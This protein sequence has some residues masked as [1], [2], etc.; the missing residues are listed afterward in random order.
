MSARRAATVLVLLAIASCEQP[1]ANPRILEKY[2]DTFFRE[3]R[4]ALDQPMDSLARRESFERARQSAQAIDRASGLATGLPSSLDL[5]LAAET[6]PR[7]A[8]V[9]ALENIVDGEAD[10]HT[11]RLAQGQLERDPKWLSESLTSDSLYSDF[12]AFLNG[13]A[14]TVSAALTGNPIGTLQPLILGI[15]GVV[16]G[17]PLDPRDRKRIVLERRLRLE[18]ESTSGAAYAELKERVEQLADQT[19][20]EELWL[21]ARSVESGDFAAALAHLAVAETLDLRAEECVALKSRIE[22]AVRARNRLL[23]TSLVVEPTGSESGTEIDAMLMRPYAGAPSS[24]GNTLFQAVGVH[25]GKDWFL[26]ADFEI[27]SARLL[28]W[29]AAW[30]FVFTG[31]RD[32]A[33]AL[34]HYVAAR[35]AETRSWLDVL[36]PIL[37]VPSTLVRGGYAIF[38]DPIDDRALIDAEVRFV[39]RNPSDERR[40]DILVELAERYQRR[41]EPWKAICALREAGDAGSERE[42]ERAEKQ[43]AS[44]ML[45]ENA[46]RAVR[47]SR[48][49]WLERVLPDTRWANEART[50]REKLLA[51]PESKSIPLGVARAF[52]RSL[53]IDPHLTNDDERD[54]ELDPPR[55]EIEGERVFA[56]VKTGKERR[57]VALELSPED[58]VR[59]AALADEWAWRFEAVR[60]ETYASR[61]RGVPVELYA[62]LGANGLAFYPRLLPETYLGDD[63]SFYR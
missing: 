26:A 58:R 20:R 39:R 30:R 60:A 57:I 42:L 56:R 55:I 63:E 8:Q 6:S 38:G 59:A 41:G 9:S 7:T 49:E 33:D 36:A 4:R 46:T 52:L 35:R 15:E 22:D 40:P 53:A 50:E 3:L 51:E 19:A 5:V 47:L 43:L 13:M 32:S 29:Y 37:W 16:R 11:Q 17:Q 21:G 27:Q 25:E 1:V 48:L 44:E 54:G 14:Q 24:V 61:H 10:L 28:R 45:D 12:T 34:D 23:S 31:R 2:E 18:G 62:G